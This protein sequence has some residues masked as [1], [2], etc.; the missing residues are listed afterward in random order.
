MFPSFL[1]SLREGLEIALVIGIVSGALIKTG[2][3]ELNA[4]VWAGALAAAVLSLATAIALHFFDAELEGRVEQVFEG[5]TMLLA[6]GL[7][8]WM[9]F[10][11][12][13]NA[14]NIKS[15]LEVSVRRTAF[16]S[17]KTGLF[18]LA[19]LAVL[20]EGI[21]LA[22]FLTAAA[23]ATNARQTAAGALVGLAGAGFLGWLLFATTT[24]LDLGRFFQITGGLL[25]LFAAGLVALSVHE[26]IETGWVPSIIEHV[27]DTNFLLN[28]ESALGQV[29]RALFGYNSAPSLAEILAYVTYFVAIAIGLKRRNIADT[30]AQKA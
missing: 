19:F 26:F 16:Q 27:W 14:R 2:R 11:M 30:A 10:W 5:T 28:G 23:L 24:R 20:R 17:G 6:A 9:I 25:I 12:Q 15:N 8:T 4:M 13:R 29:A 3:R 7:L 22:L 1:L 21:E 18:L